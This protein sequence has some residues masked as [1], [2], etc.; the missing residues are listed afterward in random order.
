MTTTRQE[1]EEE[2]EETWASIGQSISRIKN[3]LSLPTEPVRSAIKNY[4]TQVVL[5]TVAIGLALG[6][7]IG[8]KRKRRKKNAGRPDTLPQASAASDFLTL[9]RIG[10]ASGLSEE[11][12]VSNALA[13]NTSLA[14]Q[15]PVQIRSS[16]TDRLTSYVVDMAEAMIKTGLRVAAREGAAW[17]VESVRR[18][19]P[20]ASS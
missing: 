10:R 20:E 5:G 7:L 15:R 18:D 17:L 12:A 8:G 9:V 13:A 4:P 11:A 16:L 14:T 1:V 19:K 6:L 2:L 3:D